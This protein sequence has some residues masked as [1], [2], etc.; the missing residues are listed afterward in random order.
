MRELTICNAVRK[1][2][3]VS[4]R[5][6]AAVVIGADTLV[7]FEG[8]AIGKPA[9]L[10][11]A[12][13][14]LRRLQGREHQVCTSIYI[15]CGAMRQAHCVS[16]ISHVQFRA[17]TDRQIR[18]YLAK[19][20]PLDKAGA[21]AAQGHGSEIIRRIRGSYTNVV[22]LPMEEALAALAEFGVAA[23]APPAT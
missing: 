7:S 21:Y 4:R 13:A 9:D 18:L 1:A 11:E 23:A 14:I 22:G 5:E 3:A 19:I 8:E 20:D 17:L 10:Q 16:V 6:R 2:I 12:V 15:C